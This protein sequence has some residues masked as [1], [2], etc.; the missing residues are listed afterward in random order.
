MGE[1][2]KKNFERALESLGNYCSKYFK[3]L[4]ETVLKTYGQHCIMVDFFLKLRI[5]WYDWFKGLNWANVGLVKRL[6]VWSVEN[7]LMSTWN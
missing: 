6:Y 2:A 4:R 7:M 3:K 5:I 1:K